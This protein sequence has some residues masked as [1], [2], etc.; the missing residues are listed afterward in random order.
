M[1][2]RDDRAGDARDDRAGDAR[3]DALVRPSHKALDASPRR[4]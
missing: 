1:S 2:V 3:D 4:L